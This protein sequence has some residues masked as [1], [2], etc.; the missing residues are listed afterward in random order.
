MKILIGSSAP[1]DKGSGIGNYAKEL[2]EAFLD[3]GIEIHYASPTPADTA[4]LSENGI[5]HIP[6]HQDDDPIEK[7]REVL[8][9]ITDHQIIG[10]INNDNSLLQSITPGLPCPFIAV[11]HLDR[12]SI[13]ALA[14]FRPE[15][16]DYIVAISYE[17][18]EKFVKKYGISI[19]KSPIIFNGV[20]DRIGSDELPQ[21]SATVL[22]CIYAG[23]YTAMKGG[24]HIL[25]AVSSNKERW[26][27]IELHWFGNVPQRVQKRISAFSHVHYH[28][29]V[30]RNEFLEALR[31]SD[32]LLLPS[33]FE[34]CPMV[35][36][37]AM[38]F[39]VVPIASDGSGAMRWLITSGVEGFICHL[40][41]WPHQMMG[42]LLH[43]RNN[44]KILQE[45]RQAVRKRYLSAFQMVFTANKLLKLLE[46]PTINRQKR[47]SEFKVLR[48]HRPL[49][50]DGLKAPLIDRF[51]IRFG[52]IRT[53]G[54]LNL[55]H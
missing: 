21:K 43:L 26:N 35:M 28:G 36:L 14:C 29:R 12:K 20:K 8:S 50:P 13:A 4:W 25:S 15:W 18:Q 7:A 19:A 41:N 3:Q 46:T 37:E 53:A 17:M 10:V 44:Q 45:M 47:I 54:V 30:D 52:I 11:G 6:T 32:V 23:G 1:S 49:R 40:S 55:R 16:S 48:W 39:G 51:C 31:D 22:K 27:G 34:G 38:S 9:H 24:D 42:C 33:R 5:R 2:S